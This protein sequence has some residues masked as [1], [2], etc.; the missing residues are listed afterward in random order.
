MK[1]NNI[2]SEQSIE[3]PWNWLYGSVNGFS[4]WI[5]LSLS[6]NSNH[7]QYLTWYYWHCYAVKV[8]V[9]VNV[10]M[11]ELNV[12]PQSYNNISKF[13]KYC[14]I[15]GNL[16]GSLCFK[17]PVLKVFTSRI[18]LFICSKTFYNT[19]YMLSFLVYFDVIARRCFIFIQAYLSG[20]IICL[21]KE[22]LMGYTICLHK[23]RFT[24]WAS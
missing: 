7:L 11:I 8:P 1:I 12:F 4:F 3:F 17:I 14:R 22:L 15:L 10:N 18:E 24:C 20:Y 9:F 21:H 6:V 19:Q 2:F 16:A 23:E 5:D 13:T